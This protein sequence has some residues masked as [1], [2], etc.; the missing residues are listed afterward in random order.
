MENQHE[1]NFQL[2]IK[3]SLQQRNNKG[4]SVINQP[5]FSKANLT[6]L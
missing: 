1:K 3:V 2:D 6:A 5:S 4:S